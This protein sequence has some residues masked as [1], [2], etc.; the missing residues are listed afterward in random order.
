MAKNIKEVDISPAEKRR[1]KDK[2]VL[3]IERNPN[4][5]SASWNVSA[6]FFL[7]IAGIIVYVSSF[8]VEVIEPSV[9]ASGLLERQVNAAGDTD[10]FMSIV[11]FTFA[12]LCVIISGILLI[13]SVIFGVRGMISEETKR[14]SGILSI[15]TSIGLFVMVIIPV[16]QF[17]FSY[18]L[19]TF[20]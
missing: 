17:A 16:V 7:V 5:Q 6:T 19:I 18:I 12:G 3:K 9:I 14:G 20:V 13:C 1:Q 11:I 4:I 10:E 15:L 8:F 2:D